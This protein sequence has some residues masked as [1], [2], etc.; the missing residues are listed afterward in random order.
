MSSK[1][2][3]FVIDE[4][5]LSDGPKYQLRS[6]DKSRNE[7]DRDLLPPAVLGWPQTK[8]TSDEK[9]V[10]SEVVSKANYRENVVSSAETADTENIQSEGEVDEN[11]TECFIDAELETS[12]KNL[13]MTSNQTSRFKRDETGESSETHGLAQADKREAESRDRDR[14]QAAH[15]A[16]LSDFQNR[17][18]TQQS[19]SIEADK[20]DE[21]MDEKQAVAMAKAIFSVSDSVIAPKPFSGKT[22]NATSN[23]SET[24]PQSWLDFF[25]L[26]CRHRGNSK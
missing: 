20:K 2:H 26:Y 9:T 19:A 10:E 17:F 25:E 12:F 21:V 7:T 4:S 24:D 15:Q 23:A 8:E 18:Q 13:T 16:M 6:G 1:S 3:K 11:N 22:A 5:S 14:Q